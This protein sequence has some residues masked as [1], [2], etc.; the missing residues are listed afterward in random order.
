MRIGILRRI[1]ILYHKDSLYAHNSYPHTTQMPKTLHY[2][3]RDSRDTAPSWTVHLA[4]APIYMDSRDTCNTILTG[5]ILSLSFIMH[6]N[7]S[8]RQNFLL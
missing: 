7:A 1:G 2:Y 6:Q 5:D 4:D 8:K 3:L